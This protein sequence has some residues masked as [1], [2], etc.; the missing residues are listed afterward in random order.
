MKYIFLL[1][2]CLLSTSCLSFE[3]APAEEYLIY[4]KCSYDVDYYIYNPNL[5][6]SKNGYVKKKFVIK[7]QE[8]KISQN[9]VKYEPDEDGYSD[10]IFFK[11]KERLHPKKTIKNENN[12]NKIYITICPNNKS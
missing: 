2:T 1:S 9:Y 8:N 10:F 4:N 5:D 11:D 12:I 3:P 7:S 6:E